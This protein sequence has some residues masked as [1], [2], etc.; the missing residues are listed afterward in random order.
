[1]S[2]KS[3]TSLHL[4]PPQVAGP[5][6]VYPIFGGDPRLHYQSLARA[7]KQGAVVKEVDENGAVND[8]LVA[9][10][11][12]VP[13]LLFEGELIEGA[14]QNRTIDAPVLVPAGVELR[15]PVSCI[16]QGRWDGRQRMAR[17]VPSPQAVDPELRHAKRAQA[18]RQAA[19]GRAPRPDQ[20]AVWSEV[21]ARLA[22]HAVA[23]PSAALTDVYE[24]RRLDVDELLAPIVSLEQQIG[25]VVELLGKP[26]ALDL[27]G[28]AEVFGDLLPRLARGY[29]LQALGVKAAAVKEPSASAA[30]MFLEVA[31]EGHRRWLPTPGMGDAFAISRPG[32]DG[33][34]L[35]AEGELVAL[36]AFPAGKR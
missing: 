17:F 34:G 33:C 9:N 1:M 32:V 6:A 12:D 36:S 18:N 8:V 25:V 35:R 10:V 13:V 19:A 20:G 11:T 22:D 26:V 31:L 21:K 7:V 15:V 27:V 2:T 4:G 14:R 24:A 16:E 5:L 23:S 3:L 30:E 28:R 29:A